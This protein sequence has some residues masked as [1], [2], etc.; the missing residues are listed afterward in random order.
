MGYK[1]ICSLA[2]IFFLSFWHINAQNNRDITVKIG[3]S[4]QEETPYQKVTE[5]IKLDEAQLSVLYQFKHGLVKNENISFVI[6]TMILVVGP[7][8]SIYFDRNE[9]IRSEALSSYFNHDGQ[10]GPP[11]AFISISYGEFTEIAIDDNKLFTPSISGETYQL[12]KDRKK[13]FVTVMDFDNSNFKDE[14]FFFYEEE[15][16]PINWEIKDDTTSVLGYTCSKAICDFEGRSY[17]AWFTQ[18]IPINDGP[19]KFFGLPG[20]ILK[21]EDSENFF[22]FV[23]IGLEK[24]ENAEI[25]IDDKSKYQKCTKEEYKTLKKRMQENFTVFYRSG[26]ILYFCN[27]KSGIEYIPIEKDVN[28]K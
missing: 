10:D 16:S 17:S 28:R 20:M 6:D 5:K 11:R 27:Q 8:Y 4:Y 12:Y 1:V 15:M 18:D 19:Y 25:V 9:K 14:T 24:M 2:L 3:G 26:E 23:A 22:Q 13:N 21:I 7:Q